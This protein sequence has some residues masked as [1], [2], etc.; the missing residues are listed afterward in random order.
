M[1]FRFA[2]LAGLL[3]AP[4][5]LYAQDAEEESGWSGKASLGYLATSGNTKNSTLNSNFA[6]GY[7]T[8]DWAHSAEALA[9]GASENDV[10]TA[11]AY[12]L[13]WKSERELS[14]KSFLFGRLQWRKD[15]F[16]AYDTQ[17][18]QT[19]GYG[20]RLIE[21]DVHK[22]NLE[23][24]A[25]ARQSELQLGGNENETIFTAG[26]YYTWIF[27]ESADFTQNLSTEIGSAN[28]Y[29]ESYTA[30]KAK[31]VGNLALVASYTIKHNTDVP[32]LIE[33]TDTYTALALEYTF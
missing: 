10:T 2:L 11:E 1:F 16:G 29:I 4:V 15:K 8:G 33:K 26:G 27:S 19:V 23:V 20:R 30:L 7:A 25:G 17:F 13:G 32:P 9:I 6:V 18:S 3:A 21:T 24:G 12:D 31:L 22:L 5:S 28:T 14:E